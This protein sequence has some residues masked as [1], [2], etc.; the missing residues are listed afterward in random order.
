MIESSNGGS[1]G[2]AFWTSDARNIFQSKFRFAIKRG[3]V[4]S[5]KRINTFID[6]TLKLLYIQCLSGHCLIQK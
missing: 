3:N 2:L 6:E 4:V 1:S 5:V